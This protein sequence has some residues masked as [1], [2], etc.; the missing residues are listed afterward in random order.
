MSTP[1]Q[2]TTPSS[3]F[4]RS[5]EGRR[6][7]EFYRENGYYFAKGVFSRDEM[8]ELEDG[9]DT[10]V[11]Q[12]TAG[13]ADANAFWEG[14]F[15]KEMDDPD[16][17]ILHTHQV[18]HFH[19][20]WS[21]ALFHQR[22]LDIAECTIGPDIVLHHTKLFQK[23]PEKGA[24]FPL[25]Q[26]LWYFPTRKDSMMA[27]IIH[28][29]EATDEMGCVRVV[30]G[31]HKRGRVPDSHGRKHLPFHE[32]HPMDSTEACIAEPGDVLYFS[33]LALHGSKPNVSAKTRKTVLIQMIAGDDRVEEGNTHINDGLVLRGRK[34]WATRN[35]H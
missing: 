7:A 11:A 18:H 16:K 30:P 26:D 17:I 31:S 10:I 13:G 15:R 24:P 1:V 29:S 35:D 33:Y 2:T 21:R 6:I 8:A 32:E 12:I 22:F 25:H 5:E 28:V 19:A 3:P 4:A 9:F 20:A 34:P 23:P 27:A 14:D